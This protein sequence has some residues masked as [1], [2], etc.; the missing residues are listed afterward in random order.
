MITESLILKGELLDNSSQSLW[1]VLAL[2]SLFIEASMGE[3]LPVII[4]DLVKG[5][6]LSSK[7]TVRNVSSL[8]HDLSSL[9]NICDDLDQWIEIWVSVFVAHGVLLLDIAL[10][11]GL[12]FKVEVSECGDHLVG[13]HISHLGFTAKGEISPE[14][15]VLSELGPVLSDL[16]VEEVKESLKELNDGAFDCAEF[17]LFWRK[18]ANLCS[19][20][21]ES[22]DVESE[23]MVGNHDIDTVKDDLRCA[24]SDMLVRTVDKEVEDMSKVLADNIIEDLAC[25]IWTVGD[26]IHQQVRKI[27]DCVV[28]IGL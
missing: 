8:G 5:E 2:H 7:R 16:S 3:D 12:T 27:I 23:A 24:G 26:Q 18:L 13:E 9:E 20:F 6:A 11:W 1:V 19:F 21:F 17:E 22:I 15:E 28:V 4:A 25:Q 10:D 14:F